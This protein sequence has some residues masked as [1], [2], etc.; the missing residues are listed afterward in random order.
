LVLADGL[1]ADVVEPGTMPSLFSLGWEYTRARAADTVSPSTT[2]AALSSLAT[3]VSPLTHGFLEPGLPL[4][5]N[6]VGLKPL[7]RQLAAARLPT[8]LVSSQMSPTK[9]AVMR[10]M[11][12]AAGIDS[13]RISGK[14]ARDTTAA[15]DAVFSRFERSLAILYLKDC[16]NAGHAHGWMSDEYLEAAAEVD[17]AIGRIAASSEHDLLI[18]TAD[19]GGGGVDPKDHDEPHPVN[20]RVPLILAGPGI[21]RK[22]II[23]RH[24]SILDIPPTILWAFG[25]P[26]PDCYEGRVLIEAFAG[27]EK[28]L[29][30]FQ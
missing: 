24:V 12:A 13:V 4:L 16:D 11:V 19:H 10:A 23:G 29:P 9:S 20:S 26:A 22:R 27:R 8:V 3:G 5:N 1:R 18:V 25:L 15:A 2:V 6:L 21:A 30:V 14:R 28:V 7:P 17:A